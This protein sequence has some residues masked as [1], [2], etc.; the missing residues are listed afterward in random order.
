MNTRVF[1][2]VVRGGEANSLSVGGGGGGRILLG[3][4]KEVFY[5]VVRTSG[6]ILTIQT[7]FKAKNTIL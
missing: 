7:F 4:G 5:R 6:V 2:I 1:Q 3:K